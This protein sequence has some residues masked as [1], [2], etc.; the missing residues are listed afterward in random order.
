M[1]VCLIITRL[2]SSSLY[3]STQ[4][5]IRMLTLSNLCM[6]RMLGR[7]RNGR[8][9]C[10]NEPPT[11]GL[12]KLLIKYSNSGLQHN[13]FREINSHLKMFLFKLTCVIQENNF[14]PIPS[15]GLK[16][17]ASKHRFCKT[18]TMSDAKTHSG[19]LVVPQT[20][21]KYLFPPLV[22]Y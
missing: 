14:F 2:F 12:R 3:I 18:L 9:L 19:S 6:S 13:L 17:S 5:Q 10:T 1:S 16:T 8:N 15:I 11:T 4:F 7:R 21:A 22:R 20:T